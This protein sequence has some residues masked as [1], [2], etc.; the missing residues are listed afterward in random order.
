M[1]KL[2]KVKGLFSKVN[3]LEKIKAVFNKIIDPFLN[4]LVKF[5]V[6]PNEVTSS[7]F[8]FLAITILF[9]VKKNLVVSGLFL[10]LTSLVDAVDGALAKKVGSTRFGDFYDAF[11]DRIVEA[12][13]YLTISLAYP[14]L[15]LP[16]FFAL[17]FSFMTSYVAARAEVWTIGVKIKYLGIGSRTG[18]LVILILAFLFN[19]LQI[20]LYLIIIVAGITMIGRTYVTMKILRSNR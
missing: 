11:L 3:L 14:E 4:T 16:S 13:I 7:V 2:E 19:Q 20:G 1:S 17:A 18:R 10:I 15:Y 8:F 9:L 6:T 5:H 12:A